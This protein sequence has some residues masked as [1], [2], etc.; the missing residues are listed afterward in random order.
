M[1][2]QRHILVWTAHSTLE[3]SNRARGI[4]KSLA[5]PPDPADTFASFGIKTYDSWLYHLV[6]QLNM[7]PKPKYYAAGTCSQHARRKWIHEF[8]RSRPEAQ[9][10]QLTVAKA[11]VPQTVLPFVALISTNDTYFQIRFHLT[12]HHLDEVR[13]NSS[14]HCASKFITCNKKLKTRKADPFQ[15]LLLAVTYVNAL[16]PT[17]KATYIARVFQVS[18]LEAQLHAQL[19]TKI[20]HGIVWKPKLNVKSCSDHDLTSNLDSDRMIHLPQISW[21]RPSFPEGKRDRF[22][23]QIGTKLGFKLYHKLGQVERGIRYLKPS[24]FPDS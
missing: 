1:A 23:V 24:N 18:Y 7:V 3:T 10:A 9:V 11:R 19:R 21:S 4:D 15:R 14:T 13:I 22:G 20:E 2:Q 8:S 5:V 16:E 12:F 17:V 6:P